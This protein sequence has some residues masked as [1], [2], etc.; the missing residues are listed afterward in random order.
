MELIEKLTEKIK[1]SVADYIKLYKT[2]TEGIANGDMTNEDN[3]LKVSEAF[4]KLQLT[5]SNLD[6]I[7]D[8]IVK[9]YELAS[10]ISNNHTNLV[11]EMKKI[12]PDGT[13]KYYNKDRD[14][15]YREIN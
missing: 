3:H 2:F 15:S 14:G 6:E 7:F 8:F 5:F 13:I 12:S 4:I 10:L 1:H 9:N 11:E